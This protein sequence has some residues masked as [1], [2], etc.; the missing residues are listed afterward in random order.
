MHAFL[1]KVISP[2]KLLWSK[3]PYPTNHNA[4]MHSLDLPCSNLQFDQMC[5]TYLTPLPLILKS[6]SSTTITNLASFTITTTIV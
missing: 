2:S 5:H 3:L 1:Y 6:K 4:N